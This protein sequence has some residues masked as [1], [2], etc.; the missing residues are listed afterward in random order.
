MPITG[1]IAD[2]VCPVCGGPVESMWKLDRF[3]L[4]RRWGWCASTPSCDAYWEY[5]VEREDHERAVRRRELAAAA[6]ER[7][8]S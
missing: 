8:V 1:S 5:G 4:S 6:V 2:Q 3:K 7:A